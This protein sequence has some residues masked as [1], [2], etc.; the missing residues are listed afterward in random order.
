[1]FWHG[2]LS[3]PAGTIKFKQRTKVS[4]SYQVEKQEEN[5]GYH[6]L[7]RFSLIFYMYDVIK[8][9]LMIQITQSWGD[10][11]LNLY[12]WLSI[13]STFNYDPWWQ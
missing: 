12:L 7:V 2:I 3:T 10:R 9:A 1:M 8:Y 5:I 11:I 6:Q 4:T 13:S